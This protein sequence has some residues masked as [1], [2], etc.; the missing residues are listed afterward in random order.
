MLALFA[1]FVAA[2][3]GVKMFQ[4]KKMGEMFASMKMPPVAVTTVVVKGEKWQP[5]LNA[6]GSLRAVQGV[7]VSADLSGIVRE[8]AFRSGAPVKAGDLLV[9]LDTTQEEAQLKAALASVELSKL[10]LN[11]QR[12]LLAKKATSQA[13]YDSAAADAD[14]T[15]A[16]AD[17]IRAVI[18]RKTIY[19]PFEGVLGIRKINVGQYLE[20]GKPI[21]SLESQDPIYV[22]FSVPQQELANLA[23][24]KRVRLNV[25][26]FEGE[27]FEGEINAINSR[28]EE[29]SRN[30]QV[31]ATIPNKE[32]KLRGG[33]FVQ[34]AVLLPEQEGV[35]SVPASSIVYAPY[36]DSVY[37]V[38]DKK[39]DGTEMKHVVQ[40]F[41]KT[42]STRGDQVAILTGLKEGDEVV[43]SG[44]FRLNSGAE[45]KVDNS[46]KISNEENPAPPE[47]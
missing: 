2:L 37:V 3:A 12:D 34:A 9:K 14:K 29:A 22:E 28:V 43:S 1:L 27:H 13:E 23:I 11:R 35:L 47:T 10:Q 16:Q 39:E 15:A 24:G 38:K 46:I 36:G 4:F 7:D 26:G 30:V 31:E 45:V 33:M 41:I 17:E 6:V 42:G 44:G 19:A 5:T 18:A 32:G 25:A 21:V 8:I 40:Q 20:A